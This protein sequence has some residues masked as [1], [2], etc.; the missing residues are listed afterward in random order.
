MYLH[1]LL[2]ARALSLEEYFITVDKGFLS[3]GQELNASWK[4]FFNNTNPW[5]S[6]KEEI[7]KKVENIS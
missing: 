4:L 5:I 2:L 3:L 7:S 6:E 1:F